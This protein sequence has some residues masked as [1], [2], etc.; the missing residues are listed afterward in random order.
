MALKFRFPGFGPFKNN[1]I[2]I[3][4]N[5]FGFGRLG[6]TGRTNIPFP[7]STPTLRKIGDAESAR[8][9]S[10]GVGAP[11]TP[12]ELQAAA[13][14]SGHSGPTKIHAPD[15]LLAEIQRNKTGFAMANRFRVTIPNFVPAVKAGYA[16]ESASTESLNILCTRCSLPGKNMSTVEHVTYRQAQKLPNGYTVD[17]I[18]FEFL[19]TN[20]YSVLTYFQEWQKS[21]IN[22]EDYLINYENFYMKDIEVFQM[23][24]Q[25]NDVFGMKLKEAYPIS[26]QPIELSNDGEGVSRLVVTMAFFDFD[27]IQILTPK[28]V[29]PTVGIVNKLPTIDTGIS[30]A[31]PFGASKSRNKPFSYNF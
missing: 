13:G 19:L 6:T 28:N 22:T 7:K 1:S 2:S 27:P 14:V 24:T 23:D 9:G 17:E 30:N 3:G 18:E 21:M 25:D 12:A 11:R 31:G 10:G 26:V 29:D 16:S 4:R 5:G 8:Q 15:K 20:N